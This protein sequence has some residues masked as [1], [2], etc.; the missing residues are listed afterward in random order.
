MAYVAPEYNPNIAKTP[1]QI[2]IGLINNRN[3]K[4][5][6]EADLNIKAPVALEE[7]TA[8]GGDTS[9]DV[10]LLNMP[11]EVDGDWVTFSYK[12]MGLTELFAAVVAASKHKV[13]EVDVPLDA[14]G[15]PADVAV[16]R[17]EVMRKYNF[18][19]TEED[20][21]ITLESRGSIKVTAKAT[22]LSYVNS[23]V[24]GVVDSLVTRVAKTTL[25][26]FTAD[27]TVAA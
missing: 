6:V 15:F 25:Q 18:N 2:F 21:D 3:N 14:Q 27:S 20:Y 4:G 19:I 5:Y 17:A 12:R 24:I 26:G 7:A 8:A 11:S 22:N 1:A 13:R 9:A 16:F 23:F 10:D